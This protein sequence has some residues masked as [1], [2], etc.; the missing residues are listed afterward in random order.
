MATALDVINAALRNIGALAIEET[1]TAAEAQNALNALNN[2]LSTW[3]TE[4]LMIYAVLPQV[5]PV[6]ANQPSYTMGV[7]GNFNVP[8]PVQIEAAFMRDAQGNDY[9]VDIVDYDNY[10]RIVSKGVASSI[11]SVM[12]DDNNFP[13]K[14]LKFW[15]VASDPSYSF[16]LWTWVAVQSFAALNTVVVLPPGYQRALEYNL[17]LDLSPAYGK[18]IS[19]DLAGLA[20]SSKAQVKRINYDI[21]ELRFDRSLVKRGTVFNWLTG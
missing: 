16:V 9:E 15:P 21:K 2:M 5:F 4:N 12:W 19:N 13:L 7:G 18:S 20:A 3:N 11:P 6:I 14:T 8:R 1:A 10:S 17:A